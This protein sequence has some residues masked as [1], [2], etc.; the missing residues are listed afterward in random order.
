MKR[1]KY[2][3]KVAALM[4]TQAMM[5]YAL[6]AAVVVNL[7]LIVALFQLAGNTKTV[8]VP[9]NID[10]PFWIT[11]EEV[12]R[13]YIESLGM[14]LVSLGYNVT[15]SSIEYQTE[16]FMEWVHP[17]VHGELRSDMVR[18]ANRITR[19]NASMY[20]SP[21]RV[22]VDRGGEGIPRVAVTGDVTRKVGRRET[23]TERVSVVMSFT[24]VGGRVYLTRYIEAEDPNEPFET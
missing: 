20:F 18:L 11:Q 3:S 2:K 10:D 8:V 6:G 14:F 1:E 9:P 17:S 7:A 22:E 19:E 13:K 5:R 24:V 16:Y 21:I 15:P 12:D 23:S 4:G